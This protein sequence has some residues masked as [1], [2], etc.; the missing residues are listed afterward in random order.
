MPFLQGI[1]EIEFI[2]TPSSWGKFQCNAKGGKIYHAWV[3]HPAE[4][5]EPQ[6]FLDALYLIDQ[7]IIKEAL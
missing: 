5:I 7:Q 3:G 1:E 4:E 6:D 2:L